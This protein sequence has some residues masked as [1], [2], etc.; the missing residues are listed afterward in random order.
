MRRLFISRVTIENLILGAAAF[1]LSGALLRLISNRNTDLVLAGDRRFEFALAVVYAGLVLVALIHLRPTLRAAF[2]TPALVAL[3][4][5]TCVSFYWAE[6]P[7]LVARRTVGVVG[8]TFF[9]VVLASRLDFHDQLKLI[10]RVLRIA[11]GLTVAAWVYGKFMGMDLVASDS[12]TSFGV[13][14]Y[15]SVEG[16]HGIFNHKN[17]LGAMMALAILVEWYFPA[18]TTLSRVARVLWL[19]VYVVLLLLSDSITALTSVMLAILLMYAFRAFRFQYG[20]L[21]PAFFIGVLL[22]GA[23]L[24]LNAGSMSGALKA[25][26]RSSDLSGRIDLWHWVV[27][28]ILKR[29]MLGYGFSGF[30]RGASDESAVVETQIGWSPVYAHNGY[31]EITLS[32]GVIGLLL[33]AWFVCT[34]IKRTVSLSKLAESS[35]D[36]WPLA[37]LAFFLI[38]NLTECTILFQNNLEWGLCVATV[39]GSDPRLAFNPDTESPPEELESE[40]DMEYA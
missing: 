15:S 23:F 4:A 14:A 32:L 31:L 18:H 5:L 8:A 36:L 35:A 9:G 26:G 28:M 39:V 25:L 27:A 13:P 22:S 20:L 3:I 6:L 2:N 29:P 19:P 24:M 40:H 33:F 21:A 11:A 34:G 30:W 17:D 7:G 10:R 38:H 1:L 37:F 16:W 12:T